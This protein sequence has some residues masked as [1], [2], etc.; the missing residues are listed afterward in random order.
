MLRR[1]HGRRHSRGVARCWPDQTGRQGE[2]GHDPPSVS[3]YARTI[4]DIGALDISN[5]R[6]QASG[7][8]PQ[9]TV[10]K[11]AATHRWQ[12]VPLRLSSGSDMA[13]TGGIQPAQRRHSLACTE[14][15]AEQRVRSV[16]HGAASHV[17]GEAIG[18]RERQIGLWGRKPC[19]YAQP[20][21]SYAVAPTAA[22]SDT[23]NHFEKPGRRDK[24][25]SRTSI[26]RS[27]PVASSV[28]RKEAN[29]APS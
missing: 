18:L 10:Y 8:S 7:T 28:L 9:F 1:R 17:G 20:K 13:F 3:S 27:T 4:D 6:W 23:R 5:D 16:A 26:T 15:V 22:N 25:R 12:C 14:A 29:D 11:S 24:G 2:S 21:L 19:I